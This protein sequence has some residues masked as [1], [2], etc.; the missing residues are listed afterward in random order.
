MSSY[1]AYA[2]AKA[3]DAEIL[4]ACSSDSGGESAEHSGVA[5]LGVGSVGCMGEGVA[6]GV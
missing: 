3:C 6:S 5:G 4:G 2:C 1:D